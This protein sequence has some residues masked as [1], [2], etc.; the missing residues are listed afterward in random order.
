METCEISDSSLN[1][2]CS[3]VYARFK[4]KNGLYSC[5]LV[6]AR[7]KV[8]P[9]GMSIPRG[10]LYAAVLNA[11]T[12]HVVKSALG[13][14]ITN[15]L[16]LTD[17]QIV[18]YWIN[19]SKLQL[20]QW[21]RNRIIEIHRLTK[22]ENWYYINSKN[23][24]ADL[25]TKRRAKLSDVLDNSIWVNGHDWAKLD[26]T[27]FP[28][29]SFEEL[30]L[31]KEEIKGYE[32]EI[33]KS[34][35][36]DVEWIDKHLEVIHSKSYAVLEKGVPDKV[37]ERYL[38]SRYIMDPNKF[39]FRKVV[40]IVALTIPFVKNLK[41]RIKSTNNPNTGLIIKNEIPAQ[42]KFQNDVY[43]VTQGISPPPF[44][45]ENGLVVALSEQNISSALDYFY[46]K[47]TLEVKKFLKGKSYKNITI[48]KNGILYYT[49]RI[50]PSQIINNKSNLSDV[51]MD[52]S[53]ESFC[54]PIIEKFSP[55]A[56]AV[57]NE[58]HWY[59]NEANHSGN[60]TVMRYVQK[61]AHI[62]EGRSLVGQFRK[63]CPRCHYL[64]K[65]CIDVAM[66]PI[67]SDNL[68]IAPAF[69]FSQV[70]IVGPHNSYSNI[71]KR[72]TSKIWFVIFCCCVTG[73]VDIKVCED[74]STSS[75]VLAFIRFSCKVGFPKKLLPDAGSQL[76]KGCAS[77]TITFSDV[78]N[79][80]HE[81]GI[82]YEV[83]PV[84]A[85]YMHGKVER[86]IKH[87][88]ESFAKHLYNDRLSI[89]Q[90]ETLGDQVANSINNLPIALGKVIKDL[91][92][93]DLITPNRL[94]LA[95]NN[96]RCP[97]GQL[98]VTEDVGKIIQ[99]NNDV[100]SVWFRAWLTSYVPTLVMQPK[101]F[102]SDRDL[103]KGDVVL[104]LKNSTNSINLE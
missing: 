81:Y 45:C 101:W 99:R 54:V 62:I 74:Y 47:A 78:Q 21:L 44:N 96:N 13:D 87:V 1:L 103:K 89:I 67:S 17:S 73:A 35:M 86:K 56:F 52:L 40:R 71:N 10:E 37:G 41:I 24:I 65:K 2:A 16:S 55:L 49:G 59:D 32:N 98:S 75:F 97:V 66:G 48:E 51:C 43:L 26:K 9:K 50:L 79:R 88:K 57:I 7:S 64:R 34:E 104:F 15:R 94:L 12:G 22:R 69:Y 27:Q 63:E 38:F 102:R 3:A 18:L 84:G 53:M 23:N 83:C 6:F 93:I 58:V 76:V 19:N 31:N 100:F 80:L 70:D 8:V 68:C 91:E 95:R 30:K 46:S 39:R 36:I 92:N 82:I 4:R 60:E 90:W 61:I 72:A 29:Q 25:G 77:M 85:H 5:Q 20:K 28:I 42:F 33:L 11:S 14:Y